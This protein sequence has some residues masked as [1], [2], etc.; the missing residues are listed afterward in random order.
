MNSLETQAYKI[1]LCWVGISR[2]MFPNYNHT[3]GY[4]KSGDPRKSLLFKYSYKLL[5]ETQGLLPFSDYKFYIK[6]QLDLLKA[7]V[8]APIIDPSCMVG[9]SA[10]VRW[11]IWKKEFDRKSLNISKED[12]LKIEEETIIKKLNSTKEFL[13][14]KF[15][16]PN[17]ENIK[18]FKNEIARWVNLGKIDPFYA[19]L[20]PW[21]KKY[22]NI[23][24]ELD[25][26]KKFITEY[27]ETEF[28]KIFN[29]EFV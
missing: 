3:K 5:K 1:G 24:S 11:K 26:Y 12:T 9:D 27:V 17:E 8:E 13:F 6:A 25:I 4:P 22:C 23:I 7:N 20:S 18:V 19:I 21:I 10:W 28:K 2:K 15:G 29:H 14:G 16:E